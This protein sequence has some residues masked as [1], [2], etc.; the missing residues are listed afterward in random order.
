VRYTPRETLEDAADALEE[1]VA[2][3]LPDGQP[4]VALAQVI[5]ALRRLASEWNA[6]LPFLSEQNEELR[7][8]LGEPP[9]ALTLDTAAAFAENQRLSRLL[10]ERVAQTGTSAAIGDFVARWTVREREAT[11]TDTTQ[12]LPF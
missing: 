7:T 1:H 11:S 3:Q 5:S 8:L 10:A 2:P 6:V 12:M 4:A 9:A